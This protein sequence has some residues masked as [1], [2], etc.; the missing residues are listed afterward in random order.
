MPTGPSFQAKVTR[1][2]D[3][4]KATSRQVSFR[5]V[6]HVGG[7]RTLGLGRLEEVTETVLNPQPV[8]QLYT[9]D[10]IANSG[11][12]LQLGD[13]QLLIAGSVNEDV[14]RT[15]QIVY[16]TEVLKI[17]KYVPIAFD[18]TVVAWEVTARAIK[19]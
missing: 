10:E 18:Q 16:G 17:V 7:D 19:P 1:L 9:V 15:N 13:Y 6:D 14:L 12:F 3:R 5:K 4:F 2:L 8:V 11:G